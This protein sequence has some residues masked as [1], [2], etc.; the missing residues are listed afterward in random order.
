MS[1][2]AATQEKEHWHSIQKRNPIWGLSLRGD[3][4]FCETKLQALAHF[5]HPFSLS[6]S[7]RKFHLFECCFRPSPCNMHTNITSEGSSNAS[8]SPDEHGK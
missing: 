1:Q 5:S 6:P 8:A 2:A 4:K 7:L 3:F